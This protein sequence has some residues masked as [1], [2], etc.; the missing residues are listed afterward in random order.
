MMYVCI[1]ILF[2]NE[3]TTYCLCTYIRLSM[4]MR[5]LSLYIQHMLQH[6]TTY[7]IMMFRIQCIILTKYAVYHEKKTL[8]CSL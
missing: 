6:N 5:F 7:N 4:A 1:Y 2:T 3:Y 8:R